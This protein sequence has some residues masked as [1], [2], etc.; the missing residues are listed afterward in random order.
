MLSN[1]DL[2]MWTKLL[3]DKYDSCYTEAQ[4]EHFYHNMNNWADAI[5]REVANNETDTCGED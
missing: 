4:L 2:I 3:D 1:D 5:K